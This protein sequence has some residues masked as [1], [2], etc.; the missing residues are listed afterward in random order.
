MYPLIRLP[1]RAR[2]TAAWLTASVLG[3]FLGSCDP[4][5]LVT[6][7]RSDSVWIST[8][9]ESGWD[10]WEVGAANDVQSGSPIP[11]EVKITDDLA[12]ISDGKC[13][14]LGADNVTDAVQMWLERR[15]RLH[16]QREYRVSFGWSAG[17]AGGWEDGGTLIRI[18]AHWGAQRPRG[19]TFGGMGPLAFDTA[20]LDPPLMKA[21]L[22]DDTVASGE[23]GAIWVAAGFQGAFEIFQFICLDNITVRIVPLD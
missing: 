10:G 5:Q 11:R 6:D 8:D 16:P 7:M 20:H 18:Q 15:F 9:F 1:V 17:P 12:P 2:Y 23:D 19:E 14:F 13:A 3:P 21:F 4:L 22:V